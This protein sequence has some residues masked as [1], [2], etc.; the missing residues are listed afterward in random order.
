MIENLS[1][2]QL[3]GILEAIPVEISFVDE[4]DA[5][6]FW[7]KHQTRIFKRPLAVEGQFKI[8]ILA[9]VWTR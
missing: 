4:S 8:V 7:N 9:A 1:Q 2:E 6:R 5:V 3:V